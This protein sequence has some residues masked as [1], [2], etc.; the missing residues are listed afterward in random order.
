MS[1]QEQEWEL[2]NPEGVV[3]TR[4]AKTAPRITSLKGKRVGLYWN[5]KP[6]GKEALDEVADLLSRE[7]GDI[8]LIRFWEEV[9][10]T[11]VTAMLELDRKTISE[12]AALKPDLVICSQGD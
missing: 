7:V 8:Q 1:S 12:M 11:N 5:T 4:S 6:G 2:L 3:R 10:G 9:P